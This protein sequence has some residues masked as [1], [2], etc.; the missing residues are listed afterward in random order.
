MKFHDYKIIISHF[1]P[2]NKNIAFNNE[3]KLNVIVSGSIELKSLN[4]KKVYKLEILS[5]SSSDGTGTTYGSVINQDT[6][7]L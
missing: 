7:K 3:E 2:R 5:L 6:N 4:K 1:Y